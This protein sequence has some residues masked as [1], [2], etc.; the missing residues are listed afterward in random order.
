M[1]V[2]YVARV[3]GGPPPDDT[4]KIPDARAR[5]SCVRINGCAP[6]FSAVFL[7][8][9]RAHNAKGSSFAL[10]APTAA[11]VRQKHEENDPDQSSRKLGHRRRRRRRRGRLMTGHG[12]SEKYVFISRSPPPPPADGTYAPRVRTRRL[13]AGRPSRRARRPV[14]V[15]IP[16]VRYRVSISRPPPHSSHSRARAR[17]CSYTPRTH[18]SRRRAA[19]TDATT[20]TSLIDGGNVQGWSRARH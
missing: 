6:S 8:C 4:P 5:D 20:R 13:A 19:H 12:I 17:V 11:I 18:C 15:L 3:C 14:N 2:V 7:T 1:N 9:A 16:F 10:S